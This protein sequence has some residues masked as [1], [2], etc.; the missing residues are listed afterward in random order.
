MVVTFV[1][2]VPFLLTESPVHDLQEN[3]QPFFADAGYDS[4]AVSLRS[5]GGSDRQAGA[6]VAGTLDSHA[7]DLA[8]VVQQLGGSPVMVSHSFGG[9][10]AQK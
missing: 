5:Q 9:L 6:T 10:I 2:I 8:E 3:F 4:W 7:A 1:Q